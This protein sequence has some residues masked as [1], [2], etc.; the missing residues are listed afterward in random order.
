MRRL[1]IALLTILLIAVVAIFGAY[2]V[3][4]SSLPPLDGVRTAALVGEEA[5]IERDALG[6]VT[7]R[8]RDRND[9]AWA[10]GFVHAQDRFFQMDLARRLAAG[11]LAELFGPVAL[12]KDRDL[13]RH[14]FRATAR[15]VLRRAT[16][17][18]RDLFDA[19]AAGVNAGLES[20]DGRPFEYWPLGT[21]PAP[22]RPEDS[23]LVV[24]AMWIDLTADQLETDAA[25][26]AVRDTVPDAMYHFL[27]PAG[28]EWDAP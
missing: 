8:G 27:Y 6:V 7:L 19:Y 26:G 13:R 22:W 18:E 14:R 21:R 9:L 4:R 28:T 10:T 25:R 5:A 11:E 2:F 16:Q 17:A 20:V 3:L 24:F 12:P 15:E 23:V 1:R